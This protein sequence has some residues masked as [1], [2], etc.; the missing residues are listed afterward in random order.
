MND[1]K[2]RAAALVGERFSVWD[3]D[4]T[5]CTMAA[6]RSINTLLYFDF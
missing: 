4:K 2:G 1:I 5:V 6:G 3:F